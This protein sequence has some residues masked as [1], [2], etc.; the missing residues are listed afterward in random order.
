MQ[1]YRNIL[2]N[3]KKKSWLT[4][5]SAEKHPKEEVFKALAAKNY[6]QPRAAA[7]STVKLLG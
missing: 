3:V 1:S 6:I 5:A 7:L 4:F 2:D